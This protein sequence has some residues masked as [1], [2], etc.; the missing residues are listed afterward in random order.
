P[1]KCQALVQVLGNQRCLVLIDNAEVL[2]DPTTHALTDPDLLIVLETI[3]PI[4]TSF[5][6]LITSRE[7]VALPRNLRNYEKAIPLEEGLPTDEA[8]QV[9][10]ALDNDGKNRIVNAPRAT[11]EQLV[12]RTKGFPRALEYLVALLKDDLRLTPDKLLSN[13][14]LLSEEVTKTLA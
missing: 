11:L 13:P 12:A 1:Q 4:S 2:Q 7:R 14:A 8:I 3:L 6:V 5:K 10:I 9:L